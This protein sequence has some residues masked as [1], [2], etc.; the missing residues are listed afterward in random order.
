MARPFILFVAAVLFPSLAS[1]AYGSSADLRVGGRI[2]PGSSCSMTIG[3]G[4]LDLGRIHR[5]ALNPDHSKRTRLAEQRIKMQIVCEAAARYALVATG[6][7]PV[8]SQDT[9]DFGLVSD[10]DQ[11]PAGNLYVRFDSGSAH[12]EGARGYYTGTDTP[13]DLDHAIWGPST[14]SILPVPNSNFAMGFVT[15]IGIDDPPSPIRNFD[16]YLLVQP[17]IRPVNELDLSDEIAF[18]GDLAFEIRYF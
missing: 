3:D 5:D 9:F 8:G 16:T 11:T 6:L 7:L 12:I 18:A 2:I 4:E 10:A 15:A 17:W 13:H 14:S 1:R